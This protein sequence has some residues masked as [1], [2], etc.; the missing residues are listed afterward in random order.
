MSSP[1]TAQDAWAQVSGYVAAMVQEGSDDAAQILA[2]MHELKPAT[3]VFT[4]TVEDLRK[5]ATG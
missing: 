5:G 1:T 3:R 2:L 4:G